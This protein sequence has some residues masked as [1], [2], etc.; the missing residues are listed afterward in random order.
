MG[1]K[2]KTR[3]SKQVI[4]V[5]ASA[6]A[7]HTQCDRELNWY[8][9]Q[10]YSSEPDRFLNYKQGYGTAGHKALQAYYTSIAT[11]NTDK[12]SELEDL[13]G[14]P[15]DDQKST[16]I[17]RCLNLA[18]K[19]YEPYEA[20]IPGDEWRTSVHL[21][22]TL[23][24]YFTL[25]QKVEDFQPLMSD[26]VPLVEVKFRVLYKETDDFVVYLVG[27]IDLIANYHGQTVINDH[28]FTGAVKH[29]AFLN[30]FR[31]K[32]QPMFYSLAY[33]YLA[34]KPNTYM[35]FICNAI[36][37]SKGTQKRQQED[38][39]ELRRSDVIEFSQEQMEAFKLFLDKRITRILA[40]K[41]ADEAITPNFSACTG[42]M[43]SNCPYFDVCQSPMNERE[44]VLK[45][46]F[47][48]KP[49]NPLEFQD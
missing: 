12:L 24:A 21:Y 37:I 28:K 9:L 8:L 4:L 15:V 10:G 46:H 49:Y 43:F 41:K 39:C 13:Y 26:N 19:V 44:M 11:G 5:D 47:T 36:F 32:I 31:L 18:Y 16:L 2:T 48:Q 6:I 14:I 33:S 29:D 42:R 34:N 45:G 27:T 1:E 22:K 17:V 38:C 35:P 23:L 30:D 20:N 7:G 3:E 25:Y 40:V